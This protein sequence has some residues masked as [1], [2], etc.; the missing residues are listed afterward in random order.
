MQFGWVVL[1]LGMAG[2]ACGEAVKEPDVIQARQLAPPT[3]L[4][5]PAASPAVLSVYQFN[6]PAQQPVLNQPTQPVSDWKNPKWQTLVQSMRFTMQANQGVGLSANQV[7]E[8]FQLFLIDPSYGLSPSSEADVY[9]N[10]VITYTSKERS[11]FWHGCLSAKGEKLG[12][13][14]TWNQITIKACDLSG[15]AFTKSLKG[16]EAIIFQHEFRHLLGGGYLD[17]ANTYMTEAQ[18]MKAVAEGKERFIAPC[19]NK[20]PFL[21]DDYQ[22]GESIEMYNQRINRKIK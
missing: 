3:L 12:Q 15:K 11:G 13:V 9:I 20:M 21:L 17:H 22:V 8:P 10:P 6:N 14:A 2:A 19:D 1:F 18:F 4:K 16:I 7:G 5:A